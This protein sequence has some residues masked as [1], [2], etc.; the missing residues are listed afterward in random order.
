MTGDGDA[1]R[2]RAR[3]DAYLRAHHTMTVATSAPAGNAP[4]AAHVFYAVGDGLR[5]VF[6]SQPGSIHGQHIGEQAAVAVTVSE[7]Y[8]AWENIQGVQLWGR[9]R[10]LRGAAR[11]SALALYISRFPF[12]RDLLRAPAHA[13]KTRGIGVYE[14]EPERAAFTDN[15]SGVFGRELLELGDLTDTVP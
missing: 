6:L 12:V 2:L 8:V 10:R 1:A 5:L 14:V 9:A 3:V 13:A 7:E 11:A 15:T 4:H